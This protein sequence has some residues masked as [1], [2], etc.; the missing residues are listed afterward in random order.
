MTTREKW[1]G[2]YVSNGTFVIER[3]I[4]G[5]KFHVS[6]R[7]SSLRAAMKHLERFEVNPS[8]YRPDTI[9]QGDAVVLTEALIEEFH[10]W[11]ALRVSHEW[12]KTVRLKLY[13]WANHFAGKDLRHLHVVNDLRRY[14]AGKATPH[15]RVKALR[16]LTAWLREEKGT[17]HRGDDVTLDFKVPR[18]KPAQVSRGESKKV[19]WADFEK[20]VRELKPHMRDIAEVLGATGW[21]QSEIER[22][23]RAGWV[24]E[25][26]AGDPPEVVA[27]IGTVQKSGFEHTTNLMHA[28]HADAARRIRAKGKTP[29]R[30]RLWLTM[31]RACARAGVKPFGLGALRHSASNWLAEAGV[32]VGQTSEYVGHASEATTRKHYLDMR[33]PRVVLPKA[34]LRVVR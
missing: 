28:E 1:P 17:L 6:T 11:H 24:R 13:D 4:H 21:H 25:R 29:N 20:V 9:D 34:A 23:A 32:S 18:L 31:K 26:N 16:A 8:A 30:K 14:V 7:C 22:F 15:H 27:V 3:K 10:E 5:V 2:G 12:S 33:T 19:A